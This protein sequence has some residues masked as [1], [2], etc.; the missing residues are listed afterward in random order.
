[1]AQ[2]PYEVVRR[3]VEF[4]GPDRLP[5]ALPSMAVSDV[6][7]VNW[8]QVGTGDERLPRTVDEWGCVWSRT[9]VRNMGQVTGH[10]LEDWRALDGYIWPDANDPAL[11]EDME[12]QFEDAAGKFVLTK[13]F[14]LLF[15]RMCSLR[16]FANTLVDLGL[17][18]PRI[19]ALA[20]RI[21]E[22]DLAIIDNIARRF[23]GRIH[24]LYFTDDWGTELSTLISPALWA[25]FSSRATGASSR[26]F[27][28]PA[29][30]CGCT[31]AARSPASSTA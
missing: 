12:G 1:M 19:G 30:L 11:Y 5:V 15:E 26:R 28:G 17:G 27:T 6:H 29:G 10:P 4:K 31:L 23:P 9:E 18:D 24:G 20:D 21:V 2:T 8:S 25:P 3:A 14:M 7:W 16:G 22:F 13:I